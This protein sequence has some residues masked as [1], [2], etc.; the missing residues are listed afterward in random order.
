MSC[1]CQHL[2]L[3]SISIASLS[4]CK[5]PCGILTLHA[6]RH[7]CTVANTIQEINAETWEAWAQLLSPTAKARLSATKYV[8]H[9]ALHAFQQQQRSC[10]C[11]LKRGP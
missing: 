8:R 2:Q 5:H 11:V 3:L 9:G 7:A 1:A 6:A 10:T 4:R